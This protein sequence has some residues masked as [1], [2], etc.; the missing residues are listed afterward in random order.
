M[1]L[2]A[3][4]QVRFWIDRIDAHFTHIA[5]NQLA[6]NQDVIFNLELASKFSYPKIGHLSMP[7][8]KPV[9]DLILAIAVLFCWC[10]VDT[11]SINFKQ[12]AL[13]GNRQ[14]IVF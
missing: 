4:G 5:S 2:I 10:V 13:P 8:V 12:L 11:G 6:A 14:F 3:L 7:V 1:L 9:L